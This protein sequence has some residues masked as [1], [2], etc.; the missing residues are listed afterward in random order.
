MFY[1][2]FLFSIHSNDQYNTIIQNLIPKT[3]K[4]KFS[5]FLN[6]TNQSYILNNT[7]NIIL[8]S[9]FTK[10]GC[11]PAGSAVVVYPVG[12]VTPPLPAK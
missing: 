5:G 6:K 1:I 12:E 9:I 2:F 8:F 4:M 3:S 10:S 11:H 7:A